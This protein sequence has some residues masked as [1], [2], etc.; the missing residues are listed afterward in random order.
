M[1][2]GRDIMEEAVLG[3]AAGH[4]TSTLTV[5]VGTGGAEATTWRNAGAAV[6]PQDLALSVKRAKE[7]QKDVARVLKAAW[8]KVR[9]DDK[10]QAT[11]HLKDDDVRIRAV[12]NWMYV[13]VLT[14]LGGGQATSMERRTVVDELEKRL[15]K[16]RYDKVTVR[17]T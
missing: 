5:E 8:L 17:P 6:S 11:Q 2:A 3:E 13:E 4:G 10:V 16:L 12:G 7:E 9:P 15:G 1:K 14:T